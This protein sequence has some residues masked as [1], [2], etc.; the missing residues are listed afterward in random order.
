MKF[1]SSVNDFISLF[2]IAVVIFCLAIFIQNSYSNLTHVTS[3]IDGRRYLVRNESNKQEAADMLATINERLRKLKD[4]LMEKYPTD[5]RVMR[6]NSNY[7]P[8]N[9]CESAEDDKNTSYSVNKGEK[10][11]F[12]IRSK[13]DNSI[14][15]LNTLMFV[16][17][18]EMG[19]LASATIG[20]NQEFW[21]NF[22]FLLE[23]AVSIGLYEKVEYS[24]T[25]MDY[26]GIQITDSPIENTI[27]SFANEFTT[28]HENR[29]ATN[30]V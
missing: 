26:C 10:V 1:I 5:E 16:S 17:I 15:G 11:V 7:L 2:I 19:H 24:K 3:K 25:P 27:E 20:H 8:E 14:E 18:H 30:K 29:H 21:D 23:E 9:V 13:K 12:C 4:H 22:K 6:M 28:D